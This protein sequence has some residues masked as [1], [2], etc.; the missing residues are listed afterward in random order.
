MVGLS[1]TNGAA[2]AALRRAPRCER[3][4]VR[5]S[6]VCC[7]LVLTYPVL[8]KDLV[9]FQDFFCMVVVMCHRFSASEF[10]VPMAISC[11]NI[12][13]LLLTKK[14]CGLRKTAA[15]PAGG[16]EVFHLCVFSSGVES[17]YF[18]FVVFGEKAVSRM[19]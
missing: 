2:A 6:E 16:V 18:N 1:I 12:E 11:R 14:M 15:A 4:C 19:S 13:G 3:A 17:Y 5:I 9:H 10:V 7:R 8:N